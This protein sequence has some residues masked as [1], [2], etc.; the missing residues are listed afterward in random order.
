[1]CYGIACVDSNRH[2]GLLRVSIIFHA[3]QAGVQ[4]GRR[5]ERIP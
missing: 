1:H 2:Q 4:Q 5:R 3:N